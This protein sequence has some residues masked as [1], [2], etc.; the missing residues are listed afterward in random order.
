MRLFTSCITTL[1]WLAGAGTAHG[2]LIAQYEFEA[3]TG[4]NSGDAVTGLTGVTAFAA[5]PGQP[6]V[7]E[8]NTGVSQS[9]DTSTGS[10]TGGARAFYIRGRVAQAATLADAITG[11][12]YSNFSFTIAPSYQLDVSSLTFAAARNATTG[13]SPNKISV[14]SSVGGFTS[15]ASLGDSTVTTGMSSDGNYQDFSVAGVTG[16]AFNTL[17]SGTYEFRLYVFGGANN[18][19]PIRIDNIVLNGEVT[20]VPEPASLGLL[21]LAGLALV[22]RRRVR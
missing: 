18:G 19:D 5:G 1:G 13:S 3:S 20:L 2:A 16:A 17:G 10:Q 12:Q 15:G 4:A 9:G 14:L 21:S 8:T 6:N 11:E 7:V 22:R